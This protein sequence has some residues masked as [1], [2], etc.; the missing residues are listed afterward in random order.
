ML[1]ID[2]LISHRFR[3]FSAF[4]NTIEGLQ[5]ALDFGVKYL[6]FDVRVK[7]C[8]TPIIYHDEYAIDPAG[9]KHVIADLQISDIRKL[10]GVF[11]HMPLAED[12]FKAAADHANSDAIFLIDIKD[13]G[14]E[15]E[16]NALV[17]LAG[18]QHR[19]IY[20][21]WIP[22]VLYRIHN[23]APSIPLCLSH[24]CE[25]PDE[26]VR[27]AHHVDQ[28]EDGIIPRVDAPYIHGD[29]R[30]WYISGGLKGEM[31]DILKASKGAICVPENMISRPL[32]DYY[33]LHGLQVSAFSFTDWPT[34]KAFDDT[35]KIDLYFIDNKR[36]FDETS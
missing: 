14:F 1:P 9:R 33:H 36:I 27:A 4:E 21:S 25:S 16:I 23:L 32:S 13:L 24:W 18:I 3:G 2:R 35:F 15:I 12:L 20:V 5:K 7:R 30:G 31:L 22:E 19:S 26:K 11:A 28:S 6:E 10:G 34:I 29:R 17:H 8:G